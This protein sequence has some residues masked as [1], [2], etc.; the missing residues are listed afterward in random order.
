M[1]S[2][3]WTYLSLFAASAM[4]LF[5]AS[6]QA[7]VVPTS[8]TFTFTS[9][10]CTGGCG[11]QTGGFGTVTLTQNGSTVDFVVHLLNGNVFAKT[12]SADFQMF[13]FNATGVVAGD[14]TINQTGP[15]PQPSLSVAVGALNGDGTG[16]F[17]FGIACDTCG[18]GASPPIFAGDLVFHVANATIADLTALNN[19]GNIFVADILSGTS[20]NTGPVDVSTPG[21]PPD[22][23]EPGTLALLG[24]G[25]IGLGLS[26][27]RAA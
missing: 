8:L 21:R 7:T 10:H 4:G 22:V 18:N 13:K 3:K 6:A 17:G 16:N 27:R 19:L 20:G 24:L 11:P 2:R 14:I 15:N 9:D 23:P 1:R 26:R 25:L 12:G 5:A